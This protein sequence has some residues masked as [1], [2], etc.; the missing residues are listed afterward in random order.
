MRDKVKSVVDE[1]D[2]IN[3]L[4]H[5]PDDEYDLEIDKIVELLPTANS[6]NDLACIIQNVFT[7]CFGPTFKRNYE[8]CFSIASKLI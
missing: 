8:E 7:E 6:I 2:P 5:A 4:H 3:L 1:W